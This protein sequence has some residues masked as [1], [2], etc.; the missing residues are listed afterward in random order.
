MTIQK[1]L[2]IQLPDEETNGSSTLY[3]SPCILQAVD[4]MVSVGSKVR[5][6]IIEIKDDFIF[7]LLKSRLK[8][9]QFCIP[10]TV[11]DFNYT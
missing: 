1:R 7:T 11:T 5:K 2:L 3:W 9:T 10:Q 8:V 4:L 6:E